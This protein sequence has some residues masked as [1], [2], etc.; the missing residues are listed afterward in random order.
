MPKANIIIDG[1]GTDLTTTTFSFKR[2]ANVVST[3]YSYVKQGIGIPIDQSNRIILGITTGSPNLSIATQSDSRIGGAAVVDK[4]LSAIT[5][6][7]SPQWNND[8]LF[9]A[10]P[11]VVIGGV[12]VKAFTHAASSSTYLRLPIDSTKTVKLSDIINFYS[13]AQYNFYWCVCR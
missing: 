2:A 7:A 8:A 4:Q 12:T 5:G 3:I 1:H 13:T 10:A 11:D 9:V 6:G